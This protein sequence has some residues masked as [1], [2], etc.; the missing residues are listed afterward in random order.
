MKTIATY[1][2]ELRA[3][4][5]FCNFHE[6]EKMLRDHLICGV[7]N[8]RIQQ[9]LLAETG[10]LTYQKARD[11]AIAMESAA[12]HSKELAQGSKPETDIT[13]SKLGSQVN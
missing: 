3:L 5:E 11:I 6:L 1:I 2:A 4:S 9:R 7:N 13:E 10:E 12:K 8:N